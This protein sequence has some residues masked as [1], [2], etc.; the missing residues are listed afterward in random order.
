MNTV[1]FAVIIAVMLILTMLLIQK[2]L[3]SPE[4]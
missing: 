2:I 3:D 1:A 4:H